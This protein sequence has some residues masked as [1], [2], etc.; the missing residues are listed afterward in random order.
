MRATRT[1]LLCLLAALIAGSAD[2]AFA[3]RNLWARPLAVG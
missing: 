3:Q 2:G 1:A